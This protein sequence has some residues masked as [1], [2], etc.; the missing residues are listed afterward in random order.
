MSE[1]NKKDEAVR[2]GPETQRERWVKYGATVA[3]AVVV[4]VVLSLIAIYI[5]DRHDKRVDTTAAG[6]YSLK[7]QTVNVIKDNS[8]KIKLVGLYPDLKP[9]PG[10]EAK[11][12]DYYQPVADLLDEYAR[13][14]KNID[15]EMIDWSKER[16][17]VDQLIE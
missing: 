13:K 4:A 12:Q 7:P 1:A 8:K 6:M 3:L 10:E 9:N 15:S 14:G 5:A 16:S 2:G 17:K 11:V